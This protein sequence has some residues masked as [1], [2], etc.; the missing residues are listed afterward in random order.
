VGGEALAE[1]EGGLGL[2]GSAEAVLLELAER[3]LGQA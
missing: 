1:F 2:G 3:G